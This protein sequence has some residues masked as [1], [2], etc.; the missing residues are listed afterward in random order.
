MNRTPIALFVY[1]RPIHTMRTVEALQ[2]NHGACDSILYIYSDGPRDSADEEEVSVVRSYIKGITGFAEVIIAEREQNWG[3]AR[4]LTSGIDNVL[5]AHESII[6]LE[7]D[8]VTSPYFLQFMG[9]ALKYYEHEEQVVAVHGYTFPLGISFP[10]TFFL[11]HTGCWGWGTWKRGWDLF[12]PDGLKLLRQLQELKLIQKFDVNGAYP[13]TKMLEEQVQGKIDSW[14]IRWHASTFLKNKLNLYPG[15]SLVKNIGHD[16]SGAHCCKSTFYD[17]ILMDTMINISSIPVCENR[18]VVDS[19]E[20]Y[21]RRGH[22][23]IL[24]YWIWKLFGKSTAE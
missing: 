16:G 5:D 13:F 18:C 19:L 12:E 20:T 21:F 7:D 23:G 6:V 15:I 11:R 17:V 10:E 24:Q 3:L 8:L 22:S 2:K 9:D 4:S 1:N 14:A